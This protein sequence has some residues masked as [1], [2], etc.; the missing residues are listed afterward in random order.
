ML[1]A[2]VVQV[3]GVSITGT[4]ASLRRRRRKAR[5]SGAIKPNDAGEP[6]PGKHDAD[7]YEQQGCEKRATTLTGAGATETDVRPVGCGVP[8]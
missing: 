1:Q 5:T 6:E 7:R 4:A 2:L 3:V 8:G